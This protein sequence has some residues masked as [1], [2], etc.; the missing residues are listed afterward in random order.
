MELMKYFVQ[1]VEEGN[2]PEGIYISVCNLFMQTQKILD[3]LGKKVE[4]LKSLKSSFN[5][6]AFHLFCP[7]LLYRTNEIFVLSKIK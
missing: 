5:T 4:Y 7:Y 2:L 3:H 1:L 6:N